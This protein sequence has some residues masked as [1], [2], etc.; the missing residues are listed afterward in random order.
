MAIRPERILVTTGALA[1]VAI[2]ATAAWASLQVVPASPARAPWISVPPESEFD[3]GAG[4]R[5]ALLEVTP[6]L[7]RLP[8]ICG[9]DDHAQNEERY[10]ALF[11]AGG[12]EPYYR[13]DFSIRDSNA[14]IVVELESRRLIG[15]R[16][17]GVLAR[18]L[19][20]ADTKELEAIRRAWKDPILWRAPQLP[21]SVCLNS[22]AILQSCVRGRYTLSMEHCNSPADQALKAAIQAKF[23]LSP[24]G[25]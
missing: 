15:E 7:G 21:T 1:V 25:G 16:S 8:Y 19:F 17:P 24:D 12:F 5:G 2:L 14:S 9:R 3:G 20:H 13:A 22:G 6:M 18:R 23:P 10:V 11:D 4:S